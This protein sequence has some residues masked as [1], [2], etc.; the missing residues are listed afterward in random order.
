MLAGGRRCRFVWG[1]M[2]WQ[3]RKAIGLH[4]FCQID[5]WFKVAKMKRIKS[6]A[7]I[8]GRDHAPSVP[9]PKEVPDLLI[10]YAP[11]TSYIRG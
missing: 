2:T 5:R 3:K 10:P 9:S 6:A 1:N 8:K 4:F 7:V 11:L